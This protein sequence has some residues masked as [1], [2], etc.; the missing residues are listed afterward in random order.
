MI[1]LSVCVGSSCHLKGSYNVIQT[2][3]QLIEEYK[4]H[5]KI[6]F[7]AGFCMKSCDREG[8]AVS[9]CGEKYSVKPEDARVFFKN[10]IAKGCEGFHD[11]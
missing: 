5:D 10:T 2:F 1:E 3:Q 6:S 8:V 4:L 9:F 7:K 11:K